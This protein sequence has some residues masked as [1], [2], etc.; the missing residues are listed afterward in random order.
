MPYLAVNNLLAEQI[1]SKL[2]SS[3]G[4][5][6]ENQPK[7]HLENAGNFSETRYSKLCG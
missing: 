2:Y 1:V 4:Y 3:S 6:D 5:I 7:K